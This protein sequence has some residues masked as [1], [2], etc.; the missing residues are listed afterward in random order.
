MLSRVLM[1]IIENVGTGQNESG[2]SFVREERIQIV[3]LF[4]AI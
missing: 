2:Q 4:V 3:T 1:I